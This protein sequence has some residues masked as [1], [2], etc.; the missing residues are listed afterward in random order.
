MIAETERRKALPRCLRAVSR[1]RNNMGILKVF[2]NAA[3]RAVREGVSQVTSRTRVEV[4]KNAASTIRDEIKSYLDG[5]KEKANN[6]EANKALD[7]LKDLIDDA[8]VARREA[9]GL[10]G[11][12]G[13]TEE[14]AKEDFQ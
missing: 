8:A 5:A 13:N 7:K 3:E 1:C 2:R 12:S 10:D 4:E 9:V 11:P 6:P 14:K